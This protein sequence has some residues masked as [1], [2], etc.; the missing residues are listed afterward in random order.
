MS[1]DPTEQGRLRLEIFAD[2]ERLVEA[3]GGFATRDELVDFEIEGRRLGLI[4]RNRGIRNP[5]V[6]DSTLSVVT[7]PAGPYDD[8]VGTDG[9]LKYS[10]RSGDPIGGDNRKL[11]FA[12]ETGTP[13]ILFEKPMPNVYVPIFPAFV[14]DENF[15]DRYFLIA[16]GEAEWRAHLSAHSTEVEK[17]YVSQIVNRRVHQPVFRARVMVAYARTCAIC[18]LK[19]PEL[20]DAAHIVGDSELDGVASV[21]N[22]LALCKIHHAAYDQNLVG[23]S[24]DYLVHING[25]LLMEIDGP[26][27][28]HGLQEMHGVS[29]SLPHRE[30]DL[31][32][33]ERLDARFETFRR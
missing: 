18:R 14:I 24:G 31:P 26:M 4:D 11:R 33:Q 21:N 8:E 15:N 3:R 1:L 25:D 22:G 6:F 13:I 28:K 12:K 9:L 17:R 16:T 10:F 29:L 7:S 27:L 30:V 23:I 19:H 5:H 2:L 20:L 32:S